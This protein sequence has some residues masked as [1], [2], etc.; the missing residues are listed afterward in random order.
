MMKE[1]VHA[2][3]DLVF[4]RHCAGCNVPADESFPGYLCPTCR[5]ELLV[6]ESPLCGQCGAP[7]SSSAV[8][9]DSARCG[10]CL[11]REFAF[12]RARSLYLYD[13]RNIIKH[14]LMMMKYSGY[15]ALAVEFG[16][17]M[18][19]QIGSLLGPSAWD[20]LVPVPLHPRRQRQRGFNQSEVMA[21]AIGKSLTLPVVNG[22][23][24]VRNTKPQHGGRSTRQRNVSG[25]FALNNSVN[26]KGKSVL[27]IDDVLTTGATI[28]AC[29]AI[30]KRQDAAVVDVLTLA[31]VHWR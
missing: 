15:R 3:L 9:A 28:N 19:E 30:L 31:R 21:K 29:A 16:A 27:L 12:D 4:P 17:L 1:L 22:L 8:Q 13:S 18:G 10:R 7:L 24:R 5:A 25:A 14:L 11:R 26:V 6:I 20:I 2:I 23:R